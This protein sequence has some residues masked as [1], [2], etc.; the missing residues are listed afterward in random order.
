MNNGY[1]SL[2]RGDRD[3]EP[4][5]ELVEVSLVEDH[6]AWLRAHLE[7]KYNID[8]GELT[9]FIEESVHGRACHYFL[10][11]VNRSGNP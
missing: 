9:E 3:G 11:R 7:G 5:A 1:V 8:I 10:D 2:N 6:L 4:F